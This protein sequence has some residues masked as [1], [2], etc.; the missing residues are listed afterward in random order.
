MQAACSQASG[1]QGA[2]QHQLALYLT[3]RAHIDAE[4]QPVHGYA[5]PDSGGGKGRERTSCLGAQQCAASEAASLYDTAC[6][7]IS[8]P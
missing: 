5:A 2:A 7:A 6:A 8:N 4:R 3:L 1:S